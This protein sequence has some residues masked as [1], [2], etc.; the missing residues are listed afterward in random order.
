MHWKQQI[1][2]HISNIPG[3]RTRRRLVV[4]ES[5][6]WGSVRMPSLEALQQLSSKGLDLLSGDS[7]RYN[8]FDTLESKDDLAA[9][10]DTLRGFRDQNDNHPC[11]T[12]VC[13]VANPDFNRIRQHDFETYYWESFTETAK[14]YGHDELLVHYKEGI[15]NNLFIPEFHGREHLNVAAWMRALQRND[16]ETRLAFDHGLWGFNNKHPHGLMY[17]AAFDLEYAADIVGQKE[18]MASGLELFESLFGY[19]ARYFVPPNGPFNNQLEQTAAAHGIKYMFAPKK[20]T[21]VLGEGKTSTAYHWLGQQN[22]WGQRY[23]IRNVFFEP[24]QQNKNLVNDCLQSIA[25]AFTWNKP[26]VISTHRANFIGGL[27]EKNRTQS[28]ALLKALLAGILKRW[29]D[30]EFVTT[31]QLGE[32]ISDTGE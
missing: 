9:L 23:M 28:L 19:K 4:I 16:Q 25:I 22:K 32:E 24:G 27:D 10:F 3:W 31:A 12:P 17:Q 29:P 5:D 13:V 26:A 15:V 1:G 8:L 6:D 30:V 7:A 14:Q 2:R 21:E 11:F 18:I 20:Q